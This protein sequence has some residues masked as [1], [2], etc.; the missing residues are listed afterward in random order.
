MTNAQDRSQVI[1]RNAAGIKRNVLTEEEQAEKEKEK[2]IESMYE[3]SKVEFQNALSLDEPKFT[4]FKVPLI[5]IGCCLV[6]F[7]AG[8]FNLSILVL[9]IIMYAAC[10]IFTR[11]VKKF[12]NSMQAIVY[13]SERKRQVSDLESVEWINFIIKRVWKNIESEVCKEVFRVV[14]PILT[15]K[16]P[17]FLAGLCLSEFTLGSMPPVIKGISFDHKREKNVISLDCEMFFVPLETGKG[18]AAFLLEDSAHWNSRIVI[19]AR[20]GLALKGR[21]INVPVLV[22]NLSFYGKSRIVLKISKDLKS[23]I[24]SV[25]FCFLEQPQIDFDLSPLKAIDLM[26]LPGL[27]NF[28]HTLIDTNL[29]Q[30][31]VDPNSI[32]IDLVHKIA[33]E[34][35]PQGVVLLHI[36]SMFNKTD[37]SI[38]G[39]I[40]IDGRRLFK[41][42]QREGTQI[43]FNEYFFT[44]LNNKDEMLNIIFRSRN[45]SATQKYGTAGICLR[46]LRSIGNVLQKTQIWKKGATRSVIDTDVKFYPVIR[47]PALPNK[48][49]S[50]QA[51]YIVTIQYIENLQGQRKPRTRFYNSLVQMMVCGHLD[52]REK[53]KSESPV[54]LIQSALKSSGAATK[55][56]ATAISKNIKSGFNTI[57]GQENVEDPDMLM[58][59]SSSTFF[60]GKTKTIMETRSPVFDEKF[61]FFSRDINRDVLYLT[62]IDQQEEQTEVIGNCD[63]PLKD[64]FKGNE[65]IYKIKGAQSGRIKLSFDVHYI[66]PFISP[67]KKYQTAVRIRLNQLVTS[68]DEG[69]FYA[70]IK[71]RQESFSIDSFCYGDLPINREII[72]PVEDDEFIK[73]YLFRENLHEGEYIGSGNI[74]IKNEQQQ[75]ELQNKDDLAATIVLDVETEP[76]IGVGCPECKEN[77]QKNSKIAKTYT[78]PLCENDLN[79]SNSSEQNIEGSSIVPK[80]RDYDCVLHTNNIQ[81]MNPCESSASEEYLDKKGIQLLPKITSKMFHVVQVCFKH[82][83]NIHEDFFIEFVCD[84][85]VIKKSGVIKVQS[86]SKLEQVEKNV[87]GKFEHCRLNSNCEVFTLLCGQNPVFVRLR[88]TE[89]GKKTILGE[90]VI[91]KECFNE[92]ISLSRDNSVQLTV[93]SQKAQFKW[94]DGFSIGYLETRILSA[95]KLRGVESDGTSDPYVRV[96][97][98]N[99]KLYKTKTIQGTIEPIWNENVLSHVNISTDVLRFEIIDWNRIESNQILSFVEIPLYFLTE[100]FTEVNLHLIDAIKMRKDGSTLRL[101]FKFNK[102]LNDKQKSK[103]VLESDFI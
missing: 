28:I 81:D 10:S 20:L 31:M 43:I 69:I 48:H 7:L 57:V 97:L 62:V 32:K 91:P 26:N 9:G 16:C 49:M 46:K 13:K 17:S 53:Q 34:I 74:A 78:Q 2:E 8:Y 11:A 39:E 68:Y 38:I 29:S 65:E 66:T 52:Q 64:V 72:V 4:F 45:I 83:E 61:E 79:K 82:F 33:K 85:E 5:L 40:D 37:E 23:P 100:G 22:Q 75:V 95:S 25:E 44:I 67:F 56:L 59:A 99:K 14:N 21:G 1:R 24:Q 86:K 42:Q 71:N 96:F 18:P 6:S 54:E 90:C 102:E 93:C 3:R 55:N 101:G 73:F 41:T 19:S 98:N 89:F 58:E 87:L 76:L 60:I 80:R 77:Y 88:T 63:I 47:G 35:I 84:G 51:I 30:Q 103:P 27:N 50:G 15:E 94:Q 92:K 12:K 70:V 36:Y